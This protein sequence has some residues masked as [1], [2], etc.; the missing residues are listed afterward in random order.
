MHE[1]AVREGLAEARMRASLGA[2]QT[3]SLQRIDAAAVDRLFTAVEN[4]LDEPEG[5]AG[6]RDL[7]GDSIAALLAYRPEA[8]RVLLSRAIA[9][10]P[11]G[12]GQL[13]TTAWDHEGAE[14]RLSTARRLV[15]DPTADRLGAWVRLWVSEA[16][17]GLRALDD[18]P[19]T[20]PPL[21]D[22][23][24]ESQWEFAAWQ[25]TG[26]IAT[27]QFARADRMITALRQ[28]VNHDGTATD[29]AHRAAA[30]R[31]Q[32][33]RLK[34]LSADGPVRPE[35]LELPQSSW[36][37][38]HPVG[39]TWLAYLA[40]ST[41][42]HDLARR[43]CDEMSDEF[44]DA[45]VP[46][47]ALLPRAIAVTIAAIA[48]GHERCIDLC[49][50]I[51]AGQRGN[52]GVFYVTA[53][54][55]VADHYLGLLDAVTDDLDQAEVNLAAAVELY[56][57]AGARPYEARARRGLAAVLWHRDRGHDRPTA[58]AHNARAAAQAL[59]IGMPSIV[60]APWPPP[61][62]LG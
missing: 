50:T 4:V 19:A 15:A 26:A 9:A 24:R 7:L 60:H 27:G 47:A 16:G 49:R 21:R 13:L 36:V 43:L 29:I 40:A 38:E 12:S 17:A 39:R 56:R 61:S 37:T 14:G 34:L 18:P 25:I 41:G 31:A 46:E 48:T 2:L 10:D 53:Y 32:R 11:A 52:H 1:L 22:A 42:Q 55:G 30:L 59:T 54:W 5:G 45:L 3:Y 51:L 28:Q 8:A 33:V 58:T 44:A 35:E 62:V 6:S 57:A 20:V 23:G